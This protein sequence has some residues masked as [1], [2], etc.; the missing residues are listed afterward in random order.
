MAA[1]CLGYGMNAINKK[2][3]FSNTNLRIL[4]RWTGAGYMIYM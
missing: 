1:K 3:E 2:D 4:F